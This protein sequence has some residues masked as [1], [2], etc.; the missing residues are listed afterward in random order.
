VGISQ[1]NAWIANRFHAFAPV[2][3][4]LFAGQMDVSFPV[5][6]V[7]LHGIIYTV[8]GAAL[9]GI[10]IYL[11]RSGWSRRAWWIWPVALLILVSLGPWSAH[12]LREYTAGWAMA[13]I[14]L[15]GAVVVAAGFCRM[16]ILAY[17]AALF[18]IQVAAPLV[19]LLSQP[20]TFFRWNGVV[21]LALSLLV[22]A[23]ILAVG[24]RAT[25]S[26]KVAVG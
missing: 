7:M 11:A 1:V 18:C 13:F 9:A 19:Q 10:L 8:L 2:S 25:H 20:S 16:N 4:G 3:F 12:S 24:S 21:A 15:V 17:V 5:I 26:G 23:W 6:S 14:P 22:L